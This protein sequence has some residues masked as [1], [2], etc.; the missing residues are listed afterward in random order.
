MI[1]LVIPMDWAYCPTMYSSKTVKCVSDPRSY[2]AKQHETNDMCHKRKRLYLPF[3][4]LEM[5]Q[6]HLA[7]A[8]GPKSHVAVKH[9]SSERSDPQGYTLPVHLSNQDSP[10]AEMGSSWPYR[11]VRSDFE[12]GN[13]SQTYS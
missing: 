7:K 5:G 11:R 9:V 1:I 2:C 3:G 10:Q 4:D 13:Y 6:K 12:D 8:R